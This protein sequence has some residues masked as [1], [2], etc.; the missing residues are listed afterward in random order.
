MTIDIKA[1]RA[2]AKDKP[3][4]WMSLLQPKTVLA[5]CDEI[6]RLRVDAEKYR[7]RVAF[8]EAELKAM[9]SDEQPECN[10]HPAAPH[11]FDRTRSHSLGR[12]VC[13]CEGWMP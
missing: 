13:E 1:I 9:E 11:G 6:E 2:A 4:V 8:V 3:Y 7:L 12:Y 5:L 10:P